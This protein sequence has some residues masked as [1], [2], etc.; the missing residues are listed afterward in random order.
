MTKQDSEKPL[1]DKQELFCQDMHFYVYALV[2][3]RNDEIFYIGK[4]CGKRVSHHVKDAKAGR[5]NNV[6]KHRRIQEILDAGLQVKESIIADWLSESATLKMERE[7]IAAMKD[8]LSNIVHGV[9]TNDELVILRVEIAL[10]KIRPYEVWLKGINKDL[11]DYAIK[12]Y[13][14]LRG[15][16]DSFAIQL[17]EIASMAAKNLSGKVA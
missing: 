5:V 15:F 8:K 4:G 16:Y 3:P 12:H 1:T 9:M 10:K 7:L 17:K 6:A 2:D 13:G 14:S 11:S